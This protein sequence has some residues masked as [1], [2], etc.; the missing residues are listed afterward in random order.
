MSTI[1]RSMRPLSRPRPKRRWWL[2]CSVLVIC[3]VAVGWWG[4][5]GV[6]RASGRCVATTYKRSPLLGLRWQKQRWHGQIVS[7]HSA[8]PYAYLSLKPEGAKPRWLVVWGKGKATGSKVKVT[9]YGARRPFYSR[10]LDR[11]FAALY[12]GRI[13]GADRAQ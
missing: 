1:T 8:G 6:S 7:R 5:M 2:L 11:C 4:M 13:T 10:R 12:F 9:V 3:G